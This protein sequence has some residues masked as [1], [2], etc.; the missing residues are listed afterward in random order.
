MVGIIGLIDLSV[1]VILTCMVSGIVFA[2]LAGL[3]GAAAKNSNVSK[4]KD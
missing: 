4:D 2:F 1:K 3:A